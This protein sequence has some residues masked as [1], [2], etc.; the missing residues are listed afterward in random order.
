VFFLASYAMTRPGSPV[1][2]FA[3]VFPFSSPFAMLA[4][5][6]QDAT[7]WTHAAAVG[8]QLVC[9]AVFVRA[10]ARLF[11]VRV[12][13]SGPAGGAKEKRGLFARLRPSGA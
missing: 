4:R 13:K 9:V 6:A 11:K 8:W 12:M 7:L 3:V 5:A 1:E 2:L 10:G